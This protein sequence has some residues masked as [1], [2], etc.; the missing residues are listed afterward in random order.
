MRL[1]GRTDHGLSAALLPPI[2]RKAFC[3]KYLHG[4]NRGTLVSPDDRKVPS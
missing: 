3:N 1:L 4:C 2:R